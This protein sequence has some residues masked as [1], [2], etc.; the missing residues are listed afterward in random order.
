MIH[1]SLYPLWIVDIFGSLLML[2]LAGL[3]LQQVF[4]LY[5]RD[6]EDV[7][8][9]YL[10]W[11]VAAIFFFSLFRSLGHLVRHLLI[12]TGHGHLWRQLMPLSGGLNSVAFI[13]IF[14]VTLFF[15][16][17]LLIVNR[18]ASDRI[19]IETTSRQLLNLS[20]DVELM[21][22]DRTRAEMALDLAHQIR[23]PVMIIG[24]LF[25]RMC[26][27]MSGNDPQAAGYREKIAAQLE[28]LEGLVAGLEEIKGTAREHFQ[29]VELNG[30]VQR[31][32]DVVRT[33]AEKKAISLHYIPAGTQLPFFGN[34]QYLM[35]ALLHLLRNSIEACGRGNSITVAISATGEGGKVH[36]RDDG[37]GIPRHVLEHIFEPFYSTRDGSTGL[38]LPYV[39]QIIREHRGDITI[40][41]NKGHGVSVELMLPSHLNELHREVSEF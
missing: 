10:L 2:V 40:N 11:L 8:N 30:L 19:K 32:V 24:G 31:A 3:C 16:N 38:G 28:R 20:R 27:G 13:V 35:V 23:N 1:L 36:I 18:M 9:T 29:P 33:E 37:P 7:L 39:R 6:R 15:R 4:I 14:A 25:K 26:R 41:S 34:R 17:V 22:S 12:L 5:R 21:I